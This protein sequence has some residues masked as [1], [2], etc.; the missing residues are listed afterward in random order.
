MK[1]IILSFIFGSLCFAVSAQ[2]DSLGHYLKVAGENNPSVRAAFHT[3]EA[4][5]QKIPQMGAYEDPRLDMGF[6]LEP[7]TLTEGKQIAQ[8]QL[9]QMFPWF[10]AKKAAQTEAQH[11]ARMAFEEFRE[12]RDNLFLE[13]Y[14]Q[15]YNLCTLQQKRI[16]SEENIKLLQQLESL[17]LRKFSAGN[18]GQPSKGERPMMPG[19]GNAANAGVSMSGMNMGSP[20]SPAAPDAQPPTT[21][22]A[23]SPMSAMSGKMSGG[24]SEVLR[25]QLERLEL[26]SSVESILSEI[27]AAIARF[28][29]LLNRSPESAVLVPDSLS[30]LPFLPD[31]ESILQQLSE[32]NPMLGMVREET[33]AYEARLEMEKKMS[34]PMFGIGLQYMLM[35]PLNASEGGTM[36]GMSETLSPGSKGTMNGKDMLM[37]MISVTIP[38]Y[39]NKYRAA[40]RES[41]LLRQ[42]SEEKYAGT[43]NALQ[44]DVYLY[45]HRLDD[46]SRRITLY[47]KQA[48]LARTA[49]NLMVQEFAS[50]KSELGEVIQVQRQLLDYRLKEAEAIADY[51]ITVASLQKLIAGYEGN[52]K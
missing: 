40:Q 28:N 49:Y 11:M 34:Y 17:A 12:T 26:E 10:G 22:N 8:F 5:L 4:A 47:R 32:L 15:W 39:R 35:A 24:M 19:E 41:R 20:S 7:M 43:L 33:L 6:F 13:V 37:P 29:A 16:N 46:A 27:T 25:I 51:N 50:G 38:L 30:P 31:M 18:D 36:E 45:K 1:Q 14:T 23:P 21:P 9:M 2:T 48:A 44:S 52:I 3:Y 42:A